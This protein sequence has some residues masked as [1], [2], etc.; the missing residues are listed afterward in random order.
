VAKN[1]KG[2]IFEANDRRTFGK[3]IE[4]CSKLGFRSDLISRLHDFN[5]KRI[6]AIHK[7]LLGGTDYDELKKV[8]KSNSGLD[9]DVQKYVVLQV[10]VAS[11]KAEDL[12]GKMVVRKVLKKK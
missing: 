1:G 10:G 3:I 8:C 4:D 9:I 12:V 2:R 11:R 6:S 5:K 7:Y